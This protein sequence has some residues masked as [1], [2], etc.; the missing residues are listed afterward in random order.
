MCYIRRTDRGA[1]LNGVRLIGAHT[2]DSWQGGRHIDPS[3]IADSIQEAA[4][5][6]K[7]RL[8]NG[9]SKSSKAL[10]MFCLDPDG[11]VCSWVKPEDADPTL[12]DAAITGATGE[13]D[14]D[15]L[16]G[17]TQS[18]FSERFPNLPMELSFE[19][20]NPD[21][22]STGSRAAVMAVPDVPGRLLKDELDSMG[23]R[24]E[25]FTSLWHAIANVWDPGAGTPSQSLQRVVSSDAPIAAIILV[26]PQDSRLI[27]TWSRMGHLICAGTTRIQMTKGEHGLSP[28]VRKEDIARIGSDWLGWSSQ[29]G[30][31]PSRILFIGNSTKV[32]DPT[33]ESESTENAPNQIGLS[34]GEI[35]VALS[36][37]WPNATIDLIEHDDPIGETLGKIAREQRGEGIE[38]LVGL[39]NRPGKVHRSMYR[40]ASL[41][42]MAV[43]ATIAIF[44]YQLFHQ[45]RDISSQT[46]VIEV[47]RMNAMNSFD[48]ELVRSMFPIKD[49]S[50]KLEQ[51]RRS[52]G[53]LL[54]AP[55]KPILEELETISYVFGIPGIDLESIRLNNTAVTVTLRVEEIDQAEQVLQSLSAIKGSHLRWTSMTPKNQGQKIQAT[56]NARWVDSEGDS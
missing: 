9:S 31:A 42:L 46:S 56:Y 45:A 11:A 33:S 3:L 25:C 2:D 10:D 6:I 24:I 32:D 53:P 22:T 38:P 37:A 19:L 54:V 13:V 51:M 8:A 34:P 28:L 35:G 23:I 21:E 5:W 47:D 17:V 49:L 43:A 55:T 20:L 50:A 18:G 48:P 39:T 29:L 16:D 52:Q 12:L 7:D 30:V 40:W 4:T 44:G 15:D 27:W 1:A 41:A 14:P 26:D 36:N